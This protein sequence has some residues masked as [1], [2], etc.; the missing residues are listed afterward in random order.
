MSKHMLL[1]IF[2]HQPSAQVAPQQS[3]IL[4][5][6]IYHFHYLMIEVKHFYRPILYLF[7][8]MLQQAR[9]HS[10]RYELSPWY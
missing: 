3:L 6:D 7:V 1:S 2:W 9:R 5:T 4:S 8:D 10:L